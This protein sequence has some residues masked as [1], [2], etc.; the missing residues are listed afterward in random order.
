MPVRGRFITFEGG[1]GAGKST[2][3]RLLAEK[4]AGEGCNV[5]RTREPGGSPGAEIIRKILVEGDPERWT[6]LS[7]TLL[8]LAA[9]AD[10]VERVIEPALSGGQWVICDRFSDSTVVY[11]GAGR[12]LGIDRVRRLQQQAGTIMPDLTFMLDIEPR[13]GLM[14]TAQRGK[15]E[16][17]FEQFEDGF[18]RQLRESFLE[19]ARAEVRRCVIVDA[20]R[21]AEILA[22]EIRQHREGPPGMRAA[23]Q[24]PA[25]DEPDRIEGQRHPRETYELVG[26]DEALS[27]ASHAIRRGRPPQGWLLGGEPGIGKATLAYRIARYLL[28]HGATAGGPP[29][30]SV[31]RD[32]PVSRQIEAQAHPG[33][34][35]L[36]RPWDEKHKR[37]KSVITVD[38]LRRL[39]EFFGLKSV[40]G[41]WRIALIDSADEM[42]EQAANALL[43]VL[44]EPPRNS[45]LILVSHAPGRLLPTIR[46]RVQRLDLKPL[47]ESILDG[48]LAQ[49]VPEIAE[50]DR[51]ALVRAAG[52]SLG[53][54]LRL[55]GDQGAQLA[56]DAES[57]L[58]T[59]GSPDWIAMM[60]LAD[61][62]AKRGGEL[63]QFGEFLNQA[64]ARRIRARAESGG[65]HARAVEL[66]EQL[67]RIVFA[68]R[69]S[70]S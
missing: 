50:D 48:M 5:L 36:R 26:Q 64:V 29:D 53:L 70:Q 11:Q 8:F 32:D 43:K 6:A 3:V 63:A 17:R 52:G 51:A 68:R 15:G 13:V 57:L 61:R 23:V 38:E 65:G 34:L 35:V 59:E 58:E 4:L 33:L 66:W 1:E 16:N 25:L 46:S 24:T 49:C 42:N 10:H 41:G 37:L 20:S 14:R 30:L 39:G 2:Q 69:R 31:G 60:K 19:I 45:L 40:S 7:E 22:D 55:A 21:P 18:H 47:P 12:G 56:R 28:R 62:V 27:R 67:E 44:E 9:R 54:A